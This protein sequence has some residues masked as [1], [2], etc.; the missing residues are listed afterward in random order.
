MS[1]L[2]SCKNSVWKKDAS[3]QTTKKFSKIF[4]FYFFFISVTFSWL[5]STECAK[6]EAG[7][8]I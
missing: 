8:G 2:T 6:A 1:A 3:L 4:Y 5:S 7:H